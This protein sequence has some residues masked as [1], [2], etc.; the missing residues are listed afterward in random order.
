MKSFEYQIENHLFIDKSKVAGNGLFTSKDIKKG[1]V[2]FV[3]KGPKVIFHPT[4]K[5]RLVSFLTLL[6]LVR[7][8]ILTQ[9]LLMFI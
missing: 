7:I 3:M 5:K 4:I 8:Y 9:Y 1:N 2:A 6:E